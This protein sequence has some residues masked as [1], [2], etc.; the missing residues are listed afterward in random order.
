MEDLRPWPMLRLGGQIK[1]RSKLQV[2]YF[3]CVS[4]LL[5]QVHKPAVHKRARPILLYC[6]PDFSAI[7]SNNLKY[8]FF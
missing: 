5:E 6:K 8:S 1:V 7:T 3:P 2:F 4:L